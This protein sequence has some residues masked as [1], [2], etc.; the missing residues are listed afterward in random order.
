MAVLSPGICRKKKVS[1]S[2]LICARR[3]ASVMMTL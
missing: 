3:S 1:N 2:V